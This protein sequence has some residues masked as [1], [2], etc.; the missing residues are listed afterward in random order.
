[1]TFISFFWY[2]IAL[3]TVV[4][5]YEDGRHPDED[6]REGDEDGRRGDKLLELLLEYLERHPFCFEIFDSPGVKVY[7][8]DGV[9][10][11]Q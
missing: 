3:K 10:G 4:V 1:M 11:F 8:F 5:P 9:S 7:H 6:G 2:F